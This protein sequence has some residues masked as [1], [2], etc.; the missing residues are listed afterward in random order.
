[1]I[2]YRFDEIAPMNRIREVRCPVLLAHGRDDRVVP[3]GDMQL[4]VNHA[5]AGT[6]VRI[7]PVEEAGHDS[8]EAFQ[9]HA[10]RLIESIEDSPG[11]SQH[12]APSRMP[13]GQTSGA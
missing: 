9:R 2:G 4:I 3:I 11:H 7:L 8:V 5:A 10:D 1:V 6:P 12:P 13:T